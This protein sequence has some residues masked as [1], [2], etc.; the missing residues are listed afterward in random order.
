MDICCSRPT[1]PHTHP[2]AVL[3]VHDDGLAVM[4]G[5]ARHNR[6]PTTGPPTNWPTIWVETY[7]GPRAPSLFFSST[8]NQTPR[9]PPRRRAPADLLALFNELSASPALG[10][11]FQPSSSPPSVTL[12]FISCFWWRFR[13]TGRRVMHAWEP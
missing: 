10:W 6:D 2:D 8:T 4:R 7:T 11:K 12:G 9:L 3:C 5:E 13:G 1:P